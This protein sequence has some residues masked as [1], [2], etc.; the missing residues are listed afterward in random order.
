MDREVVQ[1]DPD[2]L[3]LGIVDVDEFA[4]AFGKVAGRPLVGDLDP[5][6]GPVDVEKDEQV[7]RA[8]APILVV[9]ALELARLGWDRLADLANQLGRALVE[10]DHRALCVGGL[11]VEVEDILHAGDVSGRP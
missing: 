1:H 6:P 10:A 4:H 9:V 8:V 3:G 11:G 5:A 2:L 7:D